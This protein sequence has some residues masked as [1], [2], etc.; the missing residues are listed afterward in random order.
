MAVGRIAEVTSAPLVDSGNA[1]FIPAFPIADG[2]EDSNHIDEDVLGHR[3]SGW[4]DYCGIGVSG[5]GMSSSVLEELEVIERACAQRSTA[6]KQ[7]EEF[8][9]TLGQPDSP[10]AVLDTGT[11]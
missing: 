5:C 3:G 11:A 7:D 4:M 8:V 6:L 1:A 2:A 9:D 10:V